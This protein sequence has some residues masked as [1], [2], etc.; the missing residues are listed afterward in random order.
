MKFRVH[1]N[2]VDVS[3]NELAAVK[4]SAVLQQN[5]SAMQCQCTPTEDTTV[6]ITFAS[7]MP[8]VAVGSDAA[9]LLIISERL[10]DK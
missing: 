5:I 2:G 6:D 9:P 1:K 8:L 4:Q 10:G 3:D 7:G